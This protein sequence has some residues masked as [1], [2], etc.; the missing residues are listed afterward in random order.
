MIDRPARDRL[1][2]NLRRLVSGRISNDAFSEA[3][4][5]ASPDR[6]VRQIWEWGDRLYDDMRAYRLTGKDRLPKKTRRSAAQA[7]LFL[8]S[9][10]PY[11]WPDL[12]EAFATRNLAVAASGIV[13][14]AAAGTLLYLGLPGGAELWAL[15]LI[16]VALSAAVLAFGPWS[17]RGQWRRWRRQGEMAAWPFLD[18]KALES[19]RRG[20]KSRLR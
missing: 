17:V 12:P 3:R 1:A 8:R 20:R 5:E 15:G 18:R 4:P 11:E 9:D 13:L 16:V 10:R 6:A 19:A 7:V 2:L 14:L